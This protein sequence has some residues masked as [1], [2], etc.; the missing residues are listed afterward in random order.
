MYGH[1]LYLQH[2]CRGMSKFQKYK[3]ILAAMHCVIIGRLKKCSN[4]LAVVLA[5]EHLEHMSEVEIFR[6]FVW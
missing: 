6:T 3:I 2:V 5:N 1:M 4:C